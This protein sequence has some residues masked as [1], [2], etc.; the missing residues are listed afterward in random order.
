[1]IGEKG[2]TRETVYRATNK[3]K[4]GALSFTNMYKEYI[5]MTNFGE[6]FT[7]EPCPMSVHNLIIGTPY[8]DA[9]GKG[10]V[11]NVACPND[12]YVEINF[13]K[14]G[15]SAN[16]FYRLNGEVYSA[17]GVVAYRIE[18]KWTE[19][20]YLVDAKT[21]EKEAVWTKKPYPENWELMYGM[22]YH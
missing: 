17:P 10:Y 15:W 3:F 4:N 11:R 14:R 9:A 19:T 7:L 20:I 2:F 18:G 6:K 8:L 21:G 22:T 13:Q 1:V 16:S 12:Q 5:Q